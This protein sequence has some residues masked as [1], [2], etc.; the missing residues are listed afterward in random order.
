MSGALS[1]MAAAHPSMS[2]E[3]PG[4]IE[5]VQPAGGRRKARHTRKRGGALP[6][7]TPRPVYMGGRKKRTQKKRKHTRKH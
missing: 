2:Y 5:L 7:Y 4:G 1:Q 3:V 6:P